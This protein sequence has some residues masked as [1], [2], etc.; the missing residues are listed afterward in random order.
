M[1]LN[2]YIVVVEIDGTGYI[3]KAFDHQSKASILFGVLE[4]TFANHFYPNSRNSIPKLLR[5]NKFK[6][7]TIN[8]NIKILSKSIRSRSDGKDSIHIFEV[9][10]TFCLKTFIS[11]RKNCSNVLANNNTSIIAN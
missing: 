4:A 6:E 1:E 7:Y 2:K 3:S 5:E 8:G 9:T 11:E 10:D